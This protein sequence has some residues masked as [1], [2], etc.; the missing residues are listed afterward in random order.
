MVFIFLFSTGNTFFCVNLVQKIKIDNLSRTLAP[1]LIQTYRI[2]CSCSLSQIQ[3]RNP[4]L[5]QVGPKNQNFHFKLKFSALTNSNM[6]SS[7]VMFTFFCFYH[8]ILFLGKFGPK[9]QNC[10]FKLKFGTWTNSNMQNSMVMLTF[11]V[12]DWKY[13]IPFLGK[14]G[15]KNQNCQFKL[16]FGTKAISNM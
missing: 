11:S 16:K 13:P 7:I 3:T 5:G 4:F 14:F 8:E 2:L 9:N 6:Q 1:R 12:L 10:Q 15:P